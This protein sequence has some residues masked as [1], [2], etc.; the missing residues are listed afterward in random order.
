VHE[1][2]EKLSRL[3]EGYLMVCDVVREEFGL[4]VE[5]LDGNAALDDVT[6][7]AIR[8]AREHKDASTEH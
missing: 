5:V 2:E 4:A 1:T 6:A 3:R 7:T 8:F